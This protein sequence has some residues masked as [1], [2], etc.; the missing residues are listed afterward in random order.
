MQLHLCVLEFRLGGLELGIRIQGGLLDAGVAQNEDDAVG[1]DS[2]SGVQDNAIDVG[3]RSGRDPTYVLRRQGAKAVHLPRH[4][5]AFDR[6]YPDK[7]AV[8]RGDGR[9]EAGENDRDSDEDDE[10]RAADQ[11]PFPE[12]G[13]CLG[14]TGNVHE[15]G[16]LFARPV[17]ASRKVISY[18]CINS[19]H[20]LPVPDR[21][22]AGR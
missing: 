4:R 21:P 17:P 9:L 7:P 14:G 8:D 16:W 5:P 15:L 19:N 13:L 10:S 11:Q 6:V 1:F 20:T 22:R 18:C 3:R 2:G 12:L